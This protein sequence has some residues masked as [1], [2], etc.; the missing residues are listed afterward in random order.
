MARKT[1]RLKVIVQPAALRD[2]RQIWDYNAESY[3]PDHA[4]RYIAFLND[5]TEGLATGYED[6]KAVSSRSE[7]RFVVFRKGRGHGHVAI[8]RVTTD[9]VE[10]LRYQH[11]A[12][13]WQGKAQRDEF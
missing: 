13:D 10:V 8:Y 7:L 4:D 2:L 1:P 5:Q 6:G 3:G 11:T 9:A 12:Q